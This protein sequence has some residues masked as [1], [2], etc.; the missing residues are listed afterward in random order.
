MDSKHERLLKLEEQAAKHQIELTPQQV[1][2][3]ERSNPCFRER[4]VQ[5]SAPA[6]LLCQDTFYVGQL[7]GVGKVYLQAV[8]DTYGSFAFA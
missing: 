5:S 7:K 4:R 2:A 1:A 8:V 6:Q 3:I